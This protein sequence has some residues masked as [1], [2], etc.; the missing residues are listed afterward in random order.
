MVSMIDYVRG[1][2]YEQMNFRKVFVVAEHF[3]EN[4]SD[5]PVTIAFINKNFHLWFDKKV[6]RGLIMPVYH[7]D[8]KIIDRDSNIL[9]KLDDEALSASSCFGLWKLLLAQKKNTSSIFVDGP[10]NKFYIYDECGILRSVHVGWTEPN[11]L[12]I[13]AYEK[14]NPYK[15]SRGHRI[16]FPLSFKFFS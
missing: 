11:G 5:S 6:E 16:F 2:L 14:D 9:S 13:H 10:F 8:L 1:K 15:W 3:R 12:S 4:L 7:H